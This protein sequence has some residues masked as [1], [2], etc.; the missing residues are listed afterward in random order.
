MSAGKTTLVEKNQQ[1]DQYSTARLL[2]I[3]ALA[4]EHRKFL[5]QLAAECCQIF[6]IDPASDSNEASWCRDIVDHGTPPDVVIDR[7]LSN[8]ERDEQQA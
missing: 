7:L 2:R 3:Q 4:E 6:G 1:L 8:R 5:D